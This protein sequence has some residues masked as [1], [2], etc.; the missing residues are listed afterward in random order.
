MRFNKLFIFIISSLVFSGTDQDPSL[1]TIKGTITNPIENSVN[2]F[3]KR[4]QLR[5]KS[6]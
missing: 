3:F 4:C 2:I 1:V 6:I 5:Y